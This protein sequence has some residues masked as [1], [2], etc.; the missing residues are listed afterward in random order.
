MYSTGGYITST[1]IVA[2]SGICR[3]TYKIWAVRPAALGL[4]RLIW[5]S[6]STRGVGYISMDRMEMY[7]Q[8]RGRLPEVVSDTI[9][10]RDVRGIHA[11][12]TYLSS[13]G[14]HE[15]KGSV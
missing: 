1:R 5:I 12:I 11:Y 9:R 13:L 8:Y 10:G 7:L 2:S 6:Y 4:G 14:R 15:A 3:I